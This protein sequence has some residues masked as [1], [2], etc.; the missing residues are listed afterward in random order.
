MLALRGISYGSFTALQ[1]AAKAPA[2][3]KAI[4]ST[5]GT[6]QRYLD[7]IHYRG[8]C[9]INESRVRAGAMEVPARSSPARPAPTPS[10]SAKIAGDPCGGN[11]SDVTGPMTIPLE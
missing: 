5:C 8:G 1:A 9:I 2:A 4:V 7:D 10:S 6:E 11:G 3:L